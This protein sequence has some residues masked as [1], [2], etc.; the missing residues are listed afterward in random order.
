MVR[1]NFNIDNE[2]HKKFKK[3]C[4]DEEKSMTEILIKIIDDLINVK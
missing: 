3:Y 4:V 2:L 1:L